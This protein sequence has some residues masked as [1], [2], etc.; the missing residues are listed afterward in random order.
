LRAERGNEGGSVLLL[1]PAG[2]LIVL[3]LAAMA[4]D[5][6]IAFLG[7][8]ELSSAVTAA[9]NDAATKALSDDAFYGSGTVELSD[10]EVARVAEERVRASLSSGRYQGLQVTASVQRPSGAGCRWTLRVEATAT[11]SY[12]FAAALPGGPDE[13]QVGAVAT[14]HPVREGSTC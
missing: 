2:I 9:A 14:S 7:E 10:A 12:L 13:A 8:R 6:S 11:V 4:V 3:V 5:S 1:F